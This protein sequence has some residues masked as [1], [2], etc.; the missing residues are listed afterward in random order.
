MISPRYLRPALILAA[1][2]ISGAKLG[3]QSG[4]VIH[5][6]AVPAPS[7][8]GNLL[9]DTD[10][11]LTSVYLPAAYAKNPQRRFPVLYL[12]HGFYA[13]D[14]AFI[15]GAYS[16]LNIRLAMDSLIATGKV[17]PMIVVTPSANNRFFG[18]FYVNSPATGSW[19]DFI[20]HDLVRYMDR[21]FRTIRSAA[22]RGLAGHSMGGYGTL[23]I[24][25][26]HPEVFSS[27]YALSPCCLDVG[28]AGIPNL[29]PAWK[30]AL[31]VRDTSD[32]R[33]AGFMADLLLAQSAIYSPDASRAPLYIDLP[34]RLVAD[35]LV[36]DS[37][38][39]ARWQPPMW[40]IDRYANNLRRLKIGFDAGRQDGFPDIPRNVEALD[41]KLSELGIPHSTR[42]YD[43]DHM[44]GV[45]RELENVVLPFFSENLSGKSP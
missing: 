36:I 2:F 25:M 31:A 23:Y 40:Q 26:R 21:H 39:N 42:L 34:Y 37:A 6:I 12:L 43:G 38:V 44:K 18:S 5:R 22:S 3:A 14:R 45:R 7:L 33:R 28:A 4:G 24:G 30:K 19:E 27:I 35:T 41:R 29:E 16:N 11:R 20:T 32:I 17:R 8:R 13:D 1:I 10:V 9:G 15:G